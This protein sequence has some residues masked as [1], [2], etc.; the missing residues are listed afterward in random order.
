VINGGLAGAF[1]L[2]GVSGF[3]I[4]ES[5][6]PIIGLGDAGGLWKDI[7]EIASNLA[8]G[9]VGAHLLLHWK[10]LWVNGR[11]Y[12]LD[13]LIKRLPALGGL[14]ASPSGSD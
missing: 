8:L 12:L 10:W 4:S 9:A 6:M 11:K 14:K 5:I 3:M 13:D 7:H 2:M 1:V